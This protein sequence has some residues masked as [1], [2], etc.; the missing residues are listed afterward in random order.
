VN[1]PSWFVAGN[2]TGGI[3]R[4]GVVQATDLARVDLGATEGIVV[5]THLDSRLMLYLFVE[6]GLSKD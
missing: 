2:A 4:L 1:G 5:G 6:L 3:S